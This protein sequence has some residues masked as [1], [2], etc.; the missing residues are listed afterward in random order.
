[1]LV[2]YQTLERPFP[3]PRVGRLPVTLSKVSMRS[4][5][6]VASVE[7]TTPSKV[8]DG[9]FVRALSWA[10]I[11][12]KSWLAGAVARQVRPPSPCPPLPVHQVANWL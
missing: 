9:L 12:S 1:M 4:A 11:S 8:K 2:P 10:V 6:L 7:W 3:D 5:S